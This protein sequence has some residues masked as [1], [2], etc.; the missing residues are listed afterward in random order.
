MMDD[1]EEAVLCPRC[2]SAPT[3]RVVSVTG[4]WKITCEN[5]AIG[6]E[7]WGETFTIAEDEWKRYCARVRSQNE[8]NSH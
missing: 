4:G 1:D 2:N 8:D 5:H 7:A 3:V 6:Y